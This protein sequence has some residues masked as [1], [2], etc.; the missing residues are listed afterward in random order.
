L[1]L[2]KSFGNEELCEALAELYF[3]ATDLNDSSARARF[4]IATFL[5]VSALKEIDY[6]ASHFHEIDRDV[7]KGF[8]HQCLTDILESEKRQLSSEDWLVD[9]NLKSERTMSFVSVL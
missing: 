7:L 2:A 4:A 8:S 5:G 9:L 1:S 6:F 3:G